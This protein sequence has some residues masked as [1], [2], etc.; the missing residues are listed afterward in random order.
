MQKT[1][2]TILIE[3]G[4]PLRVNLEQAIGL[5]AEK[6]AKACKKRQNHEKNGKSMQ[7]TAKAGTLSPAVLRFYVCA[8]FIKPLLQGLLFIG[9]HVQ[10]QFRTPP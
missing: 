1:A 4:D 8:F 3:G 5:I 6:H 10:P 9:M 7:K 2:K